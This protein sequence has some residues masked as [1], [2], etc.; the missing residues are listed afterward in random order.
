[1]IFELLYACKHLISDCSS[2]TARK[3]QQQKQKRKKGKREKGKTRIES[4][5][6]LFIV[7]HIEIYLL[8]NWKLN[9]K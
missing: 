1:M 9:F 2:H 4:Q 3:K 7:M 5:H 8:R 6:F